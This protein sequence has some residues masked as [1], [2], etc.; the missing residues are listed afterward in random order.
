MYRRMQLLYIHR[1]ARANGFRCTSSV[2]V[3]HLAV[4]LRTDAG[5]N[6]C[7]SVHARARVDVDFSLT[8]NDSGITEIR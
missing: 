4:A 2:V 3:H 6:G 7:I 5:F 8:M 1:N